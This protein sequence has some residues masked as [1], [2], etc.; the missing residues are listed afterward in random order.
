[1]RHQLP[2]A[3]LLATS[4][5]ACVN[6]PA[7]GTEEEAEQITSALEQ[8]NGGLDMEDEA[9]MFG[10]QLAFDQAAIEHDT[11]VVDTMASDPEVTALE[12]QVG[13]ERHRLLIAWGRMPADPTAT[14]G[15]DWSGSLTLSRGA[16][17]IGRTIGFEEATD[18]VVPRTSR[19][20]I[21][22]RSVTRPFADGL[23][24]RVLDPDPT[25]G[26]LRLRYASVDG[27]TIRDLDLSELRDGAIS[28][29]LGDGNRIVALA[30]RERDRCDHGFM[31]GRWVRLR[32]HLG[33]YRGMVANANGDP[34]GH[35]RGIWGQRR[36][37]DKVMFGKFIATDG[38]FRG[39]L[40]GTY[41]AG[42]WHARWL[43]STG[44]HGVARGVYFDAPDV[45]GGVF[46]G[47]WAETSCAN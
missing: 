12:S 14:T 41:D 11:Q 39:I 44:D 6:A 16:L 17:V 18:G 46:G 47:R 24:L 22:F 7:G 13:G 31:R 43:V 25:Q 23:L 28:I 34:V 4:T 15:R 5:F 37:G 29:D 38:T 8:E 10:D 45:R 26:P 40:H 2:L 30:L 32:P 35:I 33:A 20:R 1:M 42:H 21:E 27:T 9:P 3:L 19:D 36:N